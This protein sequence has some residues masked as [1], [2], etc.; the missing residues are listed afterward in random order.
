MT[1]LVIWWVLVA[2]HGGKFEDELEVMGYTTAQQCQSAADNTK[3]WD[4][5][6]CFPISLPEGQPFVVINN[7]ST[8]TKAPQP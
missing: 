4:Q 6:A 8:V 5:W 7:D 3:H 1:A 2:E